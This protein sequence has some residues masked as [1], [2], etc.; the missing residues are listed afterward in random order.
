M[1]FD[2]FKALLHNTHEYDRY[3]AGDCPWESHKSQALL[4]FKDGWFRCLGCNRSGNW[5]MLWNKLKGQ[6]I[7]LRPDNKITWH[8]PSIAGSDLESL[9][10]QSHMDLMQFESF[11][12]YIKQRGLENRIELNE[13]GYYEGWYTIPV[14]GENGSFVTAVFRAAPFIQEATGQRY[15]CKHVPVPFVPDWIRFNQADGVFV[16]F[17][18]LDAL[19]LVDMGLPV[20]T[21]TSGKDTF[22]PEWLD[23]YRK[24]I[25]IIPDLGEEHTA[26]EL[27]ASLGWRGR[28]MKLNFPDGKKDVNGFYEKG[29]GQELRNQIDRFRLDDN[30]HKKHG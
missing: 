27:A 22:N 12:W 9:C 5:M 18:M 19:T 11:Q 10:Y 16:V 7:I 25:Y 28:V 21:S 4:V 26:H 14:Y 6:N 20:M 23:K 24:R 15:W 17:G 2:D 3:I 1:V 8:M 29:K 13:L 30:L